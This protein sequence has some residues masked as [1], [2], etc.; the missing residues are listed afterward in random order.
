[1]IDEAN[2]P[3]EGPLPKGMFV[4]VPG[5]HEWVNGKWINS[6]EYNSW[7]SMIQRC[8]YPSQIN[9]ILYGGT[10]VCVCVRWLS[11]LNFLEDMGTRPEEMTIDRNGGALL[12]CKENCSWATIREQQLNRGL[13][14]NNTSGYRGTYYTPEYLNYKSVI[15]VDSQLIHLGV[16]AT[17]EEAART[18]NEGALFYN[19]HLARLNKITDTSSYIIWV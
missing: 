18:Y 16:Y 15:S 8:Y 12:Y 1:M 13:Q 7:H 6:R 3:H 10:G 5:H 11:F 2:T 4:T 14:S 9:H 19:G 17:A